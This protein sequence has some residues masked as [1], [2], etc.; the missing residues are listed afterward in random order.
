MEVGAAISVMS[1]QQWKRMFE[2]TRALEPYK[3]K[4]LQGYAGH[5]VQVI[6]QVQVDIMYGHQRK[7][8]PLLIVAGKERPPLFGRDWMQNIQL[9]WAKLHQIREKVPASII[10]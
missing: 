6:G 5:E 4:P 1:D 9:D 8:L 7:L 2:D 3:G 10:S